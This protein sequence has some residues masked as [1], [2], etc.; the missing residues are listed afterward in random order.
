MLGFF[1]AL[2]LCNVVL[3]L[4]S[5]SL[6]ARNAARV[7]LCARCAVAVGRFGFCEFP[8]VE[9]FQV[10]LIVVFA[11]NS[12][13]LN[14]RLFHVDRDRSRLLPDLCGDRL[15]RQLLFRREL[16]IPLPPA[17]IAETHSSPPR[18]LFLSLS[19][20]LSLYV[21]GFIECS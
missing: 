17:H 21:R 11:V 1:S 16:E 13:S 15:A 6:F 20:S 19:L 3:T 18:T 12:P 4:A 5:E 7:S 9:A 14:R 10:S 8:A 2:S